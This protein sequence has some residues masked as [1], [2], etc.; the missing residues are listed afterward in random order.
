M[1]TIVSTMRE[2]MALSSY[3]GFSV[4]EAGAAGFGELGGFEVGEEEVDG[5]ARL[6]A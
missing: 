1:T 5:G 6:R 2:R 4:G 3:N